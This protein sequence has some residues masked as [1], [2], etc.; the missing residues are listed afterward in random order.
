MTQKR[1]LYSL[2]GYKTNSCPAGAGVEFDIHFPNN[3]PGNTSLDFVSSGEGGK[4]VLAGGDTSEFRA[5]ALKLTLVS[6][7][8][9]SKPEMKQKLVVGAVAGPTAS[10]LVRTYVPATLSMTNSEQTAIA[11]TPIRMDNIQT[12]GF[13][14]HTLNPQDW[15]RSDSNITLRIEPTEDGGPAPW[16]PPVSEESQSE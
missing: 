7:N 8:G 12:I 1:N 9:H 15:D 4:G 10:G 3:S 14:I 11:N 6:I 16:L 2:N 13:H 5:F